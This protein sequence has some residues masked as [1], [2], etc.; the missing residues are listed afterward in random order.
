MGDKLRLTLVVYPPPPR[1]INGTPKLLRNLTQS[2]CP[3]IL[4]LNI[5]S[6]SP[7]SES[8]PHWRMTAPG[9]NQSMMRWMTCEIAH[10]ED[11]SQSKVYRSVKEQTYRLEDGLVGLVRDSVSQ[12]DVDRVVLSTR[13]SDVLWV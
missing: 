7:A 2:A 13:D 9:R 1:S 6:L 8:A 10:A 5:P 4:K 11:V 12:R 3:F